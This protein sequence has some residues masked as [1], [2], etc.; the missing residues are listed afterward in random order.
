MLIQFLKEE[1]YDNLIG[2]ID[3][4]K[5]WYDSRD[6]SLEDIGLHGDYSESS[7]VDLPRFSLIVPSANA[8]NDE[9]N[10]NDVANIKAVYGSWKELS[11]LQAHN[12]YM[13]TFYCHCV[14]QYKDYI[15]TRWMDGDFDLDQIRNLFF[16]TENRRNLVRGNALSSLWWKG[17][18]TYDSSNPNNPF[19]ITDTLGISTNLADFLDTFNS[20]NPLRARGVVGAIAEVLDEEGM[21]QLKNQAFRDLNRQ[22]N[23]HAA[24]RQLDCLS[25]E[26]IKDLAK[27]ELRECLK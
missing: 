20:F 10:Q 24:V 26:E 6:T 16:V 1:T 12:K 25:V 7:S 18:L 3:N 27:Q 22:L 11:P 21:T 17:Y 19:W 14:P 5:A 13:W 9:K 4:H 23:H 2:S 15:Q 8:N